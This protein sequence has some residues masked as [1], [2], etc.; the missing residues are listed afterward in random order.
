M[1]G[2]TPHNIRHRQV[3]NPMVKP[4]SVA[5]AKKHLRIEHMDDDGYLDRLVDAAVS[6]VDANGVL[7]K[8][9]IVRKFVL[10]F[11]EKP[12]WPVR[13][14]FSNFTELE[15]IK[16]IQDGTLVT[17]EN[18][19]FQIGSDGDFRTVSPIKGTDWPVADDVPYA[20]QICYKAGMSGNAGGVPETIKHAL[21]LLV[22]HWYEHREAVEP[23]SLMPLPFGF[24]EL[25][26]VHKDSWVHYG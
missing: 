4:I 3:G 6:Y 10:E 18:D 2:L 5:E 23:N 26:G 7:G 21:L 17:L 25:I 13:L 19:D 9:I 14:P 20:Y 12:T 15:N 24:N 1:V 16:V 8:P 22:A 11:T